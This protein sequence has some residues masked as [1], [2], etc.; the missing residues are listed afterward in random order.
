MSKKRKQLRWRREPRETGLAGVCQG[1]RGWE[2]RYG[3]EDVATVSRHGHDRWNPT[4]WHWWA[5]NDGLGVVW[6]NT[7][8]EKLTYKT[9]EEAKVACRSYVESVLVR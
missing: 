8:A 1:E 6:R 4:G 9:P 2:L 7:S 3:G 5:R